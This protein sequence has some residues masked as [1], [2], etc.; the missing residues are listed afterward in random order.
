VA[1]PGRHWGCVYAGHRLV[2]EG[3]CR[4]SSTQGN[5]DRWPA[6]WDFRVGGPLLLLGS[7]LSAPPPDGGAAAGAGAMFG[8]E[9]GSNDSDVP[10]RT[11]DPG[12][13]TCIG[14]RA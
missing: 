2:N 1:V 5:P 3:Q 11:R 10:V 4:C 13:R 8:A 7:V 6:A 9:I 12:T 14:K